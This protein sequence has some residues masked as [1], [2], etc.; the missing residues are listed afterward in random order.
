MNTLDFKIVT[1]AKEKPEQVEA[2]PLKCEAKLVWKD[3]VLSDGSQCDSEMLDKLL[4][5]VNL[6]TF[7]PP[8]LV[9][10]EWNVRNVVGVM[11]SISVDN[12]V[13]TAEFDVTDREAKQK[14][15]EGTWKNVSITYDLPNYNLLE[16]SLVAIPAIPGARITAKNEDDEQEVKEEQDEQEE[17]EEAKD[18]EPEQEEPADN[19]EEQKPV[20]NACSDD[21]DSEKKKEVIENGYSSELVMLKKQNENL[22]KQ[23]KE[24]SDLIVMNEKKQKCEGYLHKWISNGRTLPAQKE[25]ELSFILSLDD[26]QL[27]AYADL[28]EKAVCNA[29]TGKRISQ[30]VKPEQTR[31]EAFLEGYKQ[32][33]GGKA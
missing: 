13:L 25:Q 10:H 3:A 33:I 6:E 9:N 11:T 5:S 30:P 28:K 1:N 4:N 8:L 27:S 18:A 26:T 21:D 29:L 17:P 24:L 22:Q 20:E 32:F 2:E 31:T 15:A 23:V 12:D 7:Q 19:T 14:I 16:C